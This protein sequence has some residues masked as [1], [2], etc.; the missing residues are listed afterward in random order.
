MCKGHHEHCLSICF[1][2]ASCCCELWSLAAAVDRDFGSCAEGT[3]DDAVNCSS[4]CFSSSSYSSSASSVAVVVL[5]SREVQTSSIRVVDQTVVRGTLVWGGTC[6]LLLLLLLWRGRRFSLLLFFTAQVNI[7]AT[8]SSCR[9]L[10]SDHREPACTSGFFFCTTQMRRSRQS[11]SE[12]SITK[13]LSTK[14]I[15]SQLPVSL[16]KQNSQTTSPHLPPSCSS[17]SPQQQT[18]KTPPLCCDKHFCKSSQNSENKNSSNCCSS[19]NLPQQ[20]WMNKQT[21]KQTTCH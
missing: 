11:C 10:S 19:S 21:N 5:V 18:N 13:S 17:R 8:S 20:Q 16:R 14:T 2:D 9:V 7:L 1:L 4:F 6:R 15:P 12:T 3:W